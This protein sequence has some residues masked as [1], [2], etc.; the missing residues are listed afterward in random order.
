[1]DGS[2]SNRR[3]QLRSAIP[4]SLTT[5]LIIAGSC[6]GDDVSVSNGPSLSQSVYF[7]TKTTRRASLKAEEI[8]IGH[9]VVRK[10]DGL[11]RITDCAQDLRQ[12]LC[13][14][15]YSSD[16]RTTPSQ[17]MPNGSSGLP[18]GLSFDENDLQSSAPPVHGDFFGVGGSGTI[19]LMPFV[20][21]AVENIVGVTLHEIHQIPGAIRP[22]G[23][24]TPETAVLGSRFFT[25]VAGSVFE[26]VDLSGFE[27]YPGP[28]M[29]LTGQTFQAFATDEPEKF[30]DSSGMPQI[31]NAY[32]VFEAIQVTVPLNTAAAAAA[33]VGRVKLSEGSSPLPRDRV[34]F[35]YSLF[36]NADLFQDAIDVQRFT[37]GFEKTFLDG[38]ASVELRA[39]FATTLDGDIIAGGMTNTSAVESGNFSMAFKLL[40]SQTD[41]WVTSGGVQIVVPTADDL[42]IAAPNGQEIFRIRNESVRLS[43]FFGVLNTPNDRAFMQAFLQ[44]DADTNGNS[45]Q[46]NRAVLPQV[47]GMP[48]TGFTTEGNL[49]SPTFLYADVNVGYWI[50]RDRANDGLTGVA[51]FFEVHYNRNLDSPN[52]VATSVGVV[53]GKFETIETVN[54]TM[55]TTFEFGLASI[56]QLGYVVPVSGGIDKTFDGELRV[57]LSHRF[58]ASSRQNTAF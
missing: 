15:P 42:H 37:P 57:I 46:I 56:L 47:G 41:E 32:N 29:E 20:A 35:H 22:P 51:P 10:E 4:A 7:G 48:Q 49:E 5:F 39:P 30:T 52:P 3:R 36:H 17:L 38:R 27:G 14:D 43:P 55:G 54:L 31:R 53:G 1:M 19:T 28:G 44:L 34:F 21:S 24:S 40:L 58:G 50:H 26:G 9:V 8:R 18:G 6:I 13:P 11:I 25:S 33:G 23:T 16:F 2:T 12:P 45:V